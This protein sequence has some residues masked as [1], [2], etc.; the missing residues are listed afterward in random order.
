M[1]EQQLCLQ[2]G[3]QE[4]TIK[5]VTDRVCTKWVFSV[6]THILVKIIKSP[7]PKV[8]YGSDRQI[9]MF[10]LTSQNLCIKQKPTCYIPQNRIMYQDESI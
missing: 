5:N 10:I 6:E 8:Q 3:V 2:V 9:L 4:H 7:T 1:M